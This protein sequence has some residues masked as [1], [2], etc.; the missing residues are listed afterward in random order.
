MKT[1]PLPAIGA[2][3]AVTRADTEHLRAGF[4]SLSS[5]PNR[6]P[7]TSERGSPLHNAEDCWNVVGIS[8]AERVGLRGR[9]EQMLRGGGMRLRDMVPVL[10]QGLIEAA[11]NALTDDDPIAFL[12]NYLKDAADLRDHKLALMAKAREMDDSM[13][14]DKLRL[15]ENRMDEIKRAR[16]N[17]LQAR[18]YRCIKFVQK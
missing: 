2:P 3:I 4:S 16:D 1:V 8:V 13:A 12:A 14:A 18:K 17:L 7:N 15:E 6:S 11:S 9:L 10:E 5:S